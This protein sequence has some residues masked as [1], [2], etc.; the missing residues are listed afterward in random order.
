MPLTHA[1]RVMVEKARSIGG[2]EQGVALSESACAYIV[3]TIV[4]DLGLKASFPEFPR[5]LPP[6]FGEG[7][8]ESLRAPNVPFLQ[9]FERLVE[10]VPDTDTYFVSLARLLKSRLKY[11]KILRAQP[12]P[13]LEQVGPRAL[14][15]FGKLRPQ[16]L[17]SFIFW[18]KWIFDIDNRAAQETGY[19]FEPIIANAIGGV[20]ASAKRSPIRRHKNPSKGR[21]VDCIKDHRAY[22]FKLRVTIAAS[23]QGRWSEELDFPRDCRQSGFTPVLVVLDSTPNPKLNELCSAFDSANGEVYVGEAAWTHLNDMAG[24]TMAAFLGRYVHDPMAALLQGEEAPR[25]LPPLTLQM[26]RNEIAVE[27]GADGFSIV[28]EGENEGTDEAALLPEDADEEV[29]TS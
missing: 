8:I 11:E 23:G 14:L 28:R 19:L 13:T 20:S 26:R 12:I 4:A 27:V 24:P 17:S 29:P 1:Q 7:P 15:E 2:G 3:G 9:L 16:A 6:F 22:E 21:Q 25:S 18:R 10:M 5:E